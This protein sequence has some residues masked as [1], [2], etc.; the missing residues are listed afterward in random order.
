MARRRTVDDGHGFIR[1]LRIER[2]RV[3]SLDEFPFSI[4]AIHG[5]EE[6]PLHRKMTMFVG[7]NGSGKST[8][9]EAL[10]Q[11]AGFNAEGGSKNFSFSTHAEHSRLVDYMRIVRGTRRERTGF[12]LRAESYFNLATE[13]EELD[14][15]PSSSPKI[16]Q[17]YG[18]QSLHKQSH[19]ESFLALVQ[20][21]FSAQGLYL[22]D[23]PEEALSP[24]RQLSILRLIHG[25]IENGSSQFVIA[26]HS[27]ILLAY[28]GA[29]IYQ[30]AGK[31]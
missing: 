18:N 30:F 13:I 29:L 5:L 8:L 16:I 28:P 6:L 11:A 12:F 26:T 10:A 19:G 21:R 3:P 20:H 4:P 17:S 27:P 9:L 2:E 7:E 25:L 14:K 1:G 31:A 22:L 15:E 23:E 24:S